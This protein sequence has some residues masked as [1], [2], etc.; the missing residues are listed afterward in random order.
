MPFLSGVF[1]PATGLLAGRVMALIW[2]GCRD[3][4]PGMYCVEEITNGYQLCG[5]GGKVSNV[6]GRKVIP[7]T[8]LDMLAE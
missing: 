3:E 5:H 7:V 2:L 8:L 4:L 1:L 6:T